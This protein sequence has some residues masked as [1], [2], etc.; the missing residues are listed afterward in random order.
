MQ[1]AEPTAS[2]VTTTVLRRFLDVVMGS[3]GAADAYALIAPD[4]LAHDTP[5]GGGPEG[6]LAFAQH[7]RTAFPDLSYDVGECVAE[8]GLATARL[9]VSGVQRGPLPGSGLAAT[10]RRVTLRQLHMVRVVDGKVA[11]HWAARDDLALMIQLAA[12]PA[13]AAPIWAEHSYLATHSANTPQ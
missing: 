7:L 4:C 6:V 9:T 8:G 11:E 10:G 13:P 1:P 3:A 12:F 5:G 2:A